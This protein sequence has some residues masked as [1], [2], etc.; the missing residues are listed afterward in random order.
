[1][2]EITSVQNPRVKNAVRLREARH[3]REQGLILIDGVRELF[4]AVNAGVRLVEVFIC[5]S[6][7]TTAESQALL[8]NLRKSSTAG[9]RFEILEV[10]PKVF[11]KLAFGDRAEGV[12]GVAN[13]PQNKLS[14]IQLLLEQPSPLAP[15]RAPTEGWS[16]EGSNSRHPLVVVL[17]GVEKPGN[18]GAVLRSADA[19]AAAALILADSRV[20]LYNP[21]AIRASLGMI[22]TVPVCEAT[23]G[24]VL[25]WLRAHQLKIFAAKVD[26][27]APYTQADYR[28][29][30]AFVLGA[31]ATGLTSAWTA[32]DITAIHLPM[33]GVADSLNVS[34]TAA[35]LCYEALRQREKE[36]KVPGTK[37]GI[38]R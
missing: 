36:K 23:S 8:E 15:L 14:E 34:A 30:T 31:E 12:L 32:P 35:V 28:G 17:E 19:A 29:P 26:G 27:S 4:R 7:C 3:R 18:L 2:L 6:L 16:G 33:L 11:E 9:N 22:F 13:M 24:D 37:H 38:Y 10:A 5:E 20:D 21:N 25:A 1:M